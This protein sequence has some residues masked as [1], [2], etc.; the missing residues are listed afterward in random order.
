MAVLCLDR[1]HALASIQQR[2][3]R[4]GLGGQGVNPWDQALSLQGGCCPLWPPRWPW[5]QL[6]AKGSP[7]SLLQGLVTA[8]PLPVLTQVWL[9]V[10]CSLLARPHFRSNPFPNLPQIPQPKYTWLF[11][12]DPIAHITY[13]LWAVSHKPQPQQLDQKVKNVAA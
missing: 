4:G 13:G 3:G 1:H 12:Q 2:T 6:L 10:L 8:P 9:P 7:N 5:P 11:F